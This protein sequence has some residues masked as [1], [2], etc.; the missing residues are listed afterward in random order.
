MSLSSLIRGK[1]K[2][3][4][5]ATATPATGATQGVGKGRTVARV[6]TVAVAKTQE[7]AEIREMKGVGVNTLEPDRVAPFVVLDELPKRLTTAARR[8]CI[9]L[10][11]D[12]SEAVAAMLADLTY[13][14][15]TNWDALIP[16]FEAQ[17]SPPA[18]TRPR[19]VPE[20]TCG[21]CT[22]ARATPHPA[23][24]RCA[25]GVES[26]LATGGF[27][28]DDRHLCASFEGRS[29]SNQNGS[30]LGYD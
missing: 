7:P 10:H 14:D 3:G 28:R 22:Q 11:G 8:C 21:A 15:P 6:A 26:G 17:L 30:D 18:P 29:T 24:L 20:V 2:P 5:S 25:A 1:S 12:G 19:S 4:G 23:I 9:E 16:H 27:W 13:Y